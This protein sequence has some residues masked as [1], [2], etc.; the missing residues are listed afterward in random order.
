MGG[1]IAAAMR[2]QDENP[3]YPLGGLITFGMGDKPPSS[4]ESAPPNMHIRIGPDHV[5][6]PLDIK[7]KVMF[8][9]G[10]CSPEV[11]AQSKRLNAATPD[12]EIQHFLRVWLPTW[13]EK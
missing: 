4:T 6:M 10:T 12:V 3:L 7:D 9:P 2:G 13:Q 11:L 8:R 5:L 1:I